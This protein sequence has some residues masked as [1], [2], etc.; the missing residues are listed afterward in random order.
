MGTSEFM[1]W[2]S[3]EEKYDRLTEM[4]DSRWIYQAGQITKRTWWLVRNF[5]IDTSTTWWMI[6]RKRSQRPWSTKSRI[7]K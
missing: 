5:L 4:W 7:K 6:K 2:A 3:N 1:P